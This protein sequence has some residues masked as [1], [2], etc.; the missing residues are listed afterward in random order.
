MKKS[1]LI[2]CLT[3]VFCY[4]NLLGF[5]Q[6]FNT[7]KFN[8]D[9]PVFFSPKSHDPNFLKSGKISEKSFY[10]R[11]S[12][13]QHII[14]STWGPGDSLSRKLEIFNTYAKAIHDE[15]DVLCF[16][17]L[18]WD[19]LY[20]HY[21]N[22]ITKSTSK[23]AFSSIMSHFTYDLK[24]LH[25]IAL[26][27][28]VVLSAL[29]PGVPVLLLGS[30]FNVE[31]FGAVTTVLPD[32][33]NLVLRV[34]PNH[35]LNLEPGDIILGYEGIPWKNLVKELLDGDLPMFA[36]SGGSRTTDTY[37]NLC[38]AGLNW[39]LFNTL[40]I[41]KYS[42]G[43]TLHLSTLPMLNLNVPTMMNNEQMAI[44]NI[45]FPHILPPLIDSD[46]VVTYGILENTNIGYI[47]LSS[48]WPTNNAD[49][50]FYEA[51]ST[52]KN[53]DALIIDMRLNFGGRA[54]FDKAFNILFNEYH[55]TLEHAYRCNTN[56]FKLCPGGNSELFQINGKD[57][58]YYD[59]PI[60]VLLGPTCVSNGDITSHRLR[61]HPMVK[62][63][64]ASSA[65]AHGWRMSVENIPGW[66]LFYSGAD[67]FHTSEPGVYLNRREFPID[68]PV[69]FN[70]DDV[71]KGIDPIVEKSLEWI[72]NLAYGH[73][74]STE[75][76]R[77]SPGNDTVKINAIIENPNSHPISAKLIFEKLDG[78]VVDSTEMVGSFLKSGIQWQ[79]KWIA[80]NL[81][82]NNYWI[83]LKVYDHTDGTSFTNKHMTRITNR[84][85]E[86]DKVSYTDLSSNKYTIKTELKHSGKTMTVKGSTI[87]LT[88]ENTWVKS[89]TPE[90]V[91]FGGLKPG[92]I[93]RIPSFAVS[94]DEVT[95]PG[96]IN[97]TYTIIEEGWP[98]WALD[99]TIQIPTGIEQVELLPLAFG[100]E[101]N[102]PNPFNSTTT[103]NWQIDKNSKVTL[104]VFDIVGRTVATLVDE[105][106][107]QGKYETQFNAATLPQGIYFY[108]LKA[109]EFSQTRKMI[110]LE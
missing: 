94:V 3:V 84:P 81:P 100:L 12:E 32:S 46:T 82:E 16:L 43:D 9:N 22:Q 64:G 51:I 97:L 25:T 80:K 58:D 59:R 1:T 11:K 65:A 38:G 67:M 83:S 19:S 92:D 7:G 63:F 24:D 75:K 21:R 61:Y 28:T 60:A 42:S 54:F 56:T 13:W 14:D 44:K 104:K 31:H 108:Q 4:C 40:D 72:G 89:I 78:S 88:S 55:K 48:H 20:N 76:G 8:P 5:S 105:Q 17:N 93:R 73:D 98:Y 68:Y 15:S 85:V 86:I 37:E 87:K 70:K 90:Q 29:N 96:Y 106:R 109:G 57:P 110:L 52:L 71:A 99:T 23:G 74:I 101:Q 45:P 18:N 6:D 10:Q 102:Y 33:T 103:I 50:Q 91:T 35:P 41:L 30:Y 27:T 26:D 53:T 62:F 79:A 66:I 107:P 2:I 47:F 95:F 69:W 49:S 36:M 77:Y 39:H 34:V